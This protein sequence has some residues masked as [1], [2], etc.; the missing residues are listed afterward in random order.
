MNPIEKYL[1]SITILVA[2]LFCM[3]ALRPTPRP[4]SPP[5]PTVIIIP[6]QGHASTFELVRVFTDSVEV[7][8]NELRLQFSRSQVR[9]A[10]IPELGDL[11]FQATQT[12]ADIE[13]ADHSTFNQLITQS[14]PLV[15]RLRSVVQRFG[16]LVP[17]AAPALK[18]LEQ[19]IA[20]MRGS[21]IAIRN[22]SEVGN[23]IEQMANGSVPLSVT[24]EHQID[25]AL[26][27]TNRIP[28]L[29][30]RKETLDR[31]LTLRRRI[32][33]DVMKT[34]EQALGRVNSLLEDLR[35]ELRAGIVSET[36]A[37]LLL[38]EI[39]RQ[40]DRIPDPNSRNEAQKAYEEAHQSTE[41]WFTARN[42]KESAQVTQKT[43]ASLAS[44]AQ[45]SPPAALTD[46]RLGLQQ[47][48]TQV[49]HVPASATRE[50]L[51]RELSELE[52][53]ISPRFNVAPASP[54]VEVKVEA[55]PTTTRSD[56]VAPSEKNSTDLLSDWRVWAITFLFV[57]FVH[58]WIKERQDK[59]RSR[60]VAGMPSGEQENDNQG[61]TPAFPDYRPNV[62]TRKKPPPS[63]RK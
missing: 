61:P 6:R 12:I 39:K 24:W 56:E 29:S 21:S 5:G 20:D 63:P 62:H 23:R 16:W 26:E 38:K 8:E 55:E 9:E 52:M 28:Y 31:F 25:T 10:R 51:E 42:L 37:Q 27:E 35:S 7:K 4:T 41:Q 54:V 30:L 13:K 40:V 17:Q 53:V 2:S 60:L 50:H 19:G 47:A 32:R 14:E 48:R 3:G 46:L 59:R 33:L 11:I 58:S 49:S 44:L 45:A 22:L 18:S 34:A 15:A 43:I 36:G 1:F 57:W